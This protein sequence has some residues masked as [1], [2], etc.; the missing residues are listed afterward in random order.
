MAGF[1]LRDSAAFDDWQFFETDRLRRLL[2]GV[3]E[4]LVAIQQGQ[5]NFPAAIDGARRWLSLDALNEA[6][7]CALITLYAQN[8]QRNAALRQYR[9]CVRILDEELGVHPLDETTQLYEAIKENRLEKQVISNEPL[10]VIQNQHFSDTESSLL[11]TDHHPPLMEFAPQ[12]GRA[13][14]WEIL[15]QL[16]EGLRQ[17]GAF[18]AL[19]GES[20]IGKTRLAQDFITHLQNR[21]VLTLSARCYAGESNLAYAPL[22]DLL[23]QGL[24]QVEGQNWWQGL[25][26]HW[27]SEVS[28]LV[29]ELTTS[30][31]NL[32]TARPIEGPGAQTRFYEGVCQILTALVVGPSPGVI[33][34]DNLEWADQSTLDLLAYLTRRLQGRPI[35][36]MVAWQ[37]GAALLEQ[38]LSDAEQQGY[39]LHL[40]LAPLAPEQALE[41]IEQLENPAQPF[42]PDF[43]QQLVTASQ[44]LPYYLVEYLQGRSGRRNPCGYGHQSLA[45]SGRSARDA[46]YPFGK[47]EWSSLSNPASCCSD[48][49]YLRKRSAPNS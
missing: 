6:A 46:A 11:I 15:T 33:F 22:I 17:N 43:K 41:L 49:T 39:G 35:F 25:H 10:Q 42:S 36:L 37:S 21:G 44:G 5:G 45:P 28:L 19:T 16:Y 14:E 13:P 12:V 1:S 2:A 30:I 23:R 3:L 8:N 4:R 34:I 38:A 29:P 48:W 32:S 20:G 47:F 18:A 31:Q 7:H 26:L 27:L 24:S 9:E 40:P